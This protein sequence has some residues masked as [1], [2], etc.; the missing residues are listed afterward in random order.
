MKVSE[1]LFR[2]PHLAYQ[3]ALDSFL[4]DDENPDSW[5]LL[6]LSGRTLAQESVEGP[7]E[8]L[9]IIS[10]R[11]I[12]GHSD[13]VPCYMDLILPERISEHHFVIA[14]GKIARRR[15]RRTKEG[16]VI[17][18]IGIEKRGVYTLYHAPE[19]PLAGIRVL[20]QGIDQASQKGYLEWD[21][22]YLL[23]DQKMYREAID[24]FS[25]CLAEFRESEAGLAGYAY[26]ERSRLYSLIGEKQKAE[27]DKRLSALAFEKHH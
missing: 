26:Q 21:L 2:E 16:T 23:R 3:V 1:A 4:A 6:P 19:D 7:F 18:A 22:A 12:S 8:G 27:E 15:G 14:D 11:I 25:Q 24:A 5:N 9:F 13:P 20:Q 17:P 10:A